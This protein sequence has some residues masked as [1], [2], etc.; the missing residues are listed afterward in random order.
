MNRF[1]DDGTIQ[2]RV[3]AAGRPL[4]LFENGF[5]S[6]KTSIKDCILIAMPDFPIDIADSITESVRDHLEHEVIATDFIR[7]FNLTQLEAEAIVWWTVD[8]GPMFGMTTAE[9]PYWVYNTALR[10]RDGPRIMLWRDFSFFFISALQKLPSFEG[11]TFRG[12][13]RRVTELSRQY[14]RGNRVSQRTAITLYLLI[15]FG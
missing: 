10:A 11:E 3:F 7:R 8:V 2:D 5:V 15:H 9:S 12:E 14:A 6:T 4:H 1:E 13:R